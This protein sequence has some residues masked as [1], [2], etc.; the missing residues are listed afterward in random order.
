M[1]FNQ[2]RV[3]LN[4]HS[5]RFT[6]ESNIAHV[7]YFSIEIILSLKFTVTLWPTLRTG[8]GNQRWILY[9]HG[10][11]KVILCDHSFPFLEQQGAG[12][13]SP[14][15]FLSRCIFHFVGNVIAQN[16]IQLVEEIFRNY[17]PL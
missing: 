4:P 13:I 6:H 10:P 14:L 12:M 3:L 5:I 17:S 7:S 9:S 1:T 15:P 2:L 8:A 16:F 11:S